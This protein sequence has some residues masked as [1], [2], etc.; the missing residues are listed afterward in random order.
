MA[1][2]TLD[3][4]VG[5]LVTER[6][7][8][9]RIFE[10]FGIDYCCGGKKPLELACREKGVDPKTVLGVLAVL[11]EQRGD[12]AETDWSKASLRALADLVEHTHHA[13]L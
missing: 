5:Q 11:D 9:A 6:P 10:T 2:A 13:F 12:A 8:R 7:G 4:T 1:T 3:Q